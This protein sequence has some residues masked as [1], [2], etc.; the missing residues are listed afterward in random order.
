ML[1]IAIC[2]DDA[3]IHDEL[4]NMLVDYSI[5][6]DFDIEITHFYSAEA[7]L[8]A[9]FDY[10]I[11]FLDVMLDKGFDGVEIGIRLRQRNCR[12]L[13][14]IITSRADRS[15]DAYEATVFRFIVKPLSATKVSKLMDAVHQYML[16][17]SNEYLKVTYRNIDHI[18]HI[19]DIILIESYMRQRHVITKTSKQATNETWD[20]LLRKLERFPCFVRIGKSYLVNMHHIRAV[21]ASSVTLSNG[22]VIN[23]N[24][25]SLE[26][27]NCSYNAFLS[28]Q[29]V[30]YE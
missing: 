29:E 9:P 17:N 28:E 13:F 20:L 19:R 5:R 3:Y 8:G 7:L 16:Y 4:H 2:D 21:S 27:F 14:I 12:A 1:R 6:I 24:K 25:H 18:F 11:L 23:F 10:D 26:M 30:P 15:E 22:L